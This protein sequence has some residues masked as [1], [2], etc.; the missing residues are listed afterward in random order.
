MTSSN[1]IDV[2]FTLWGCDVVVTSRDVLRGGLAGGIVGG[3]GACCDDVA[4]EV[5]T[6]S[7]IRIFEDLLLETEWTSSA[8]E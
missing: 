8:D 1:Q 2:K 7:N 6:S 3:G 5:M 4:V